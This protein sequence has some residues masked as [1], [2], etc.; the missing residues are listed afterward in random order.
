M[1]ILT[2]A[3]LKVKYIK[4]DLTISNE[5]LKSLVLHIPE[6]VEGKVSKKEEHFSNLEELK[7]Y[8][9]EKKVISQE[10]ELAVS[11]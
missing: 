2:R 8:L 3:S 9:K 5:R 1:S 10:S 6:L 11:N 4:A 7:E